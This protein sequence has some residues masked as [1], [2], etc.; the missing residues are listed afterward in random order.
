MVPQ[1]AAKALAPTST[2]SYGQAMRSFLFRID[3]AS[4]GLIEKTRAFE[5]D[6]DAS[7]YATQLLRDWPEC[8]AIEVLQAGVL[9]DR[10]KP[11]APRHV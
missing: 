5:R 10:L 9:I 4:G 6:Q 7:A 11:S 3:Q 1:S 8:A 2:S